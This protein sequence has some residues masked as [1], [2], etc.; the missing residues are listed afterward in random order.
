MVNQYQRRWRKR[1][2]IGR[3]K[4]TGKEMDI[5]MLTESIMAKL[6]LA[7][8]SLIWHAAP[9]ES[10]YSIGNVSVRRIMSAK[11]NLLGS[12]RYYKSKYELSSV[13]C[14]NRDA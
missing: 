3:G 9:L 13:R 14:V 8:G 1:R 4:V 7:V 11:F 6:A 12:F 5:V 10:F 2:T